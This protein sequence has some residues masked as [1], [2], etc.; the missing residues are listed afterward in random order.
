MIKANLF[1]KCGFIG[2]VL[3][4]MVAA[5]DHIAT[6][7]AKIDIGIDDQGG[8]KD[9]KKG[10]WNFFCNHK[11]GKRLPWPKYKHYRNYN[12]DNEEAGR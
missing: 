6:A 5:L 4:Y 11:A 7:T 2:R 8:P 10:V 1:F 9:Q 3:Y 12:H